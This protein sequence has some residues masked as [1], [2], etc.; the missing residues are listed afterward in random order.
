MPLIIFKNSKRVGSYIGSL[1]FSAAGVIFWFYIPQFMQEQMHYS[2]FVSAIGM[3]PMSILLFFVALKSQSIV[4][5]FSN[6]KVLILGLILVLI[7]ALGMAFL[8]NATNYWLIFPFTLTFGT[9]FALA[10]TPLTA[11]SMAKITPNIRG[12]AS[13]V[14]NTTRQFGA[15]LG[16]AW[17]ISRNKRDFRDVTH[18]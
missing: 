12:A 13:G 9:G 2:A 18:L 15:A 7:S 5:R 4:R 1:L 17:G 10:L 6:N 14:Y 11:S 8:N 16:L 3:I